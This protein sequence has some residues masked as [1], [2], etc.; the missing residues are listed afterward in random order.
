MSHTAAFASRLRQ[1]K[2]VAGQGEEVFRF[3]CSAKKRGYGR[4]C[5]VSVF[6]KE[7]V[8]AGGRMRDKKSCLTQGTQRREEKKEA[9]FRFF[10]DIPAAK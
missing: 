6:R 7:E 8:R 10:V 5:Q 1:A 2:E 9:N 4:R 3:Q